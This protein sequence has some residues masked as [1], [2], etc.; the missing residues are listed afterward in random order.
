ME[1]KVQVGRQVA[2]MIERYDGGG[3]VGD[4]GEF[5][6]LAF[7]L[8]ARA[9]GVSWCG[10]SRVEHD[11]VNAQRTRMVRDRVEEMC[12]SGSDA[13]LQRYECG[14]TLAQTTYE[15]PPL[16]ELNLAA[17][18]TSALG[19]PALSIACSAELAL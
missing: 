17:R 14:F 4:L 18:R 11:D 12:L 9:V 15:F 1:W 6:Q 3:V 19:C 8:G 10:G 2:G 5:D 16:G 13:P 7:E